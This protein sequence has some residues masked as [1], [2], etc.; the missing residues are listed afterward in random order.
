VAVAAK[1]DDVVQCEITEP[2]RRAAAFEIERRGKEPAIDESSSRPMRRARS[3]PSRTRSTS[4]SVSDRSTWISGYVCTN[5]AISGASSQLPHA[6]GAAIRTVPL[7]V[8][9]NSITAARASLS[10]DS[11][12]ATRS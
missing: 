7:G 3:N 2:L 1:R 8:S 5:C 10:P 9:R 12:A 6:A 11:A 4:P